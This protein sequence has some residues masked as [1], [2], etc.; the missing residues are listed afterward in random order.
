MEK[1]FQMLL[2]IHFEKWIG[3]EKF[4]AC[5]T[6]DDDTL[7]TA[8]GTQNTYQTH[9]KPVVFLDE[10]I[11]HGYGAEKEAFCHHGAKE[12]SKWKNAKQHNGFVC[13]GFAVFF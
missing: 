7:D 13:N 6:H 8:Q 2:P 5:H 1:F 4:H 12:E 9:G 3:N 10:I 11:S